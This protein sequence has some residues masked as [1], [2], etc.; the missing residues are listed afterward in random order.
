M[1]ETPKNQ[2]IG[3]HLHER[4]LR[5][6]II[7]SQLPLFL[8]MTLAAALIAVL[9]PEF[10]RETTLIAGCA[11]NALLLMA[12]MVVPWNKIPPVASLVIPYLGFIAVA[13]FRDGAQEFLS[14]TGILALFPIF[15]I[16]SSG[17]APKTAVL[18]STLVSWVI[19]WIPVFQSDAPLSVDT[20]VKPLL[21]PFMMLAFSVASVVLTTSMD[22]HRTRLESKDR[23]LRAALEQSQH[24]ERLMETILDT[25]GV[26]VVVVDA[27]GNDRLV[28]STQ[29][30]LHDF[31]KP[32]GVAVP[33]E[34]DL[35]L[36]NANREPLSPEAR[37]VQRAISGESFT[38][39]QIWIG[40]GERARGLSTTARVILDEDG[41]RDGAVIAYHDVTE[42]FN[43]ITAK[44]DFLAN[45]S[46]EFRTPLTAIQSYL[47]LALETPGLHPGHVRKYLSIAD[48]NAERLSGLV[49]DLLSTTSITVKRKQSDVAR[50][51]ADSIATASPAAAVNAVVLDCQS[52]EP[53]FAMIDPVR[54]GQVLDNL[55]SNAV[56]YSPNGGTLTVRAWAEGT[57]LHCSV[58]DTGL[59]M[60][61]TEQAGVFQ[62]FFRAGTAVD[63]GIPGIG[64]GLMIC[65]TII[66]S[67]DGTLN[68]E[69]QHGVGTTMSFV[70]PACVRSTNSQ[71]TVS[72]YSTPAEV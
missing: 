72:T 49:T 50:L 57:D 7:L 21:F 22:A 14:S 18:V 26:G 70:I 37:P 2:F 4:S 11:L 33:Q 63:L 27:D 43:A 62:K 58:Q 46:H 55:L 29:M 67:H 8:T 44:D 56:K 36:F 69:S 54:I 51:L 52:E 40:A 25:V 65:K 35:L 9:N 15:W 1:S 47:E 39:Y 53:L 12:C 24:S 6:R 28:N 42:M 64:L 66:E 20:L 5:T 17:F 32:A 45:V 34:G 61:A 48:R 31:G 30:A 16:C 3:R 68:L 59:G 23:L 10:L 41:A 60:S 38:N 71:L 13:L 19:V